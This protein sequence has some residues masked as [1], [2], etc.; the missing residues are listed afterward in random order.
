D[1]ALPTHRPAGR[2]IAYAPADGPAYRLRTGR[3]DGAL[4][5][6]RPAGRRIAYAPADGPAHRLAHRLVQRQV[7]LRA[8]RKAGTVG[9]PP[10]APLAAP[11]AAC[12]VYE[13]QHDGFALAAAAADAGQAEL[14]AALSHLVGQRQHDAGAAGADGVAQRDGA[15]VDVDDFRIPLA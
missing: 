8:G 7:S 6:H 1:G 2:R 10:G 14:H 11:L 12:S 9:D 13:L 5:T 4:P 3:R 15:A